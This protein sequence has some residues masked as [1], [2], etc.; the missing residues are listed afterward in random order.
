LATL[1]AA[2]TTALTGFLGLLSRLVLLILVH[3]FSFRLERK[4]QP[5]IKNFV[6]L[7]GALQGDQYLP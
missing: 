4:N 7:P 2:L 6:P 5:T 3:R 1:L